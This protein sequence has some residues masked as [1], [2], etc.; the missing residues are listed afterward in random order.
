MDECDKGHRLTPENTYDYGHGRICRRC[1]LARTR[2][3]KLANPRLVL[4]QR[5]RHGRRLAGEAVPRA[6]WRTASA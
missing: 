4:A 6:P 2:A 5:E 1:R 3:W